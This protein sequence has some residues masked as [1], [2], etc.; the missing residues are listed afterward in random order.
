MAPKGLS[1]F[2][3]RGHEF[4]ALLRKVIVLPEEAPRA[5]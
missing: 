3:D 2:V 4:S 1:V 5:G